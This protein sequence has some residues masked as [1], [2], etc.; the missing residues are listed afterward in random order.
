MSV[1]SLGAAG[2]VEDVCSDW[3]SGVIKGLPLFSL[4]VIYG[5]LWTKGMLLLEFGCYF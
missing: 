1:C 4:D 2:H 5:L 3:P